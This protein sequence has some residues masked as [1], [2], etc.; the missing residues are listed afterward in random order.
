MCQKTLNSAANSFG[1]TKNGCENMWKNINTRLPRN[2]LVGVVY[3]HPNANIK[4]F[5]DHFNDTLQKINLKDINC[6]ILGNFNINIPHHKNEPAA[7]WINMVNFNRF[8]RF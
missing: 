6:V 8:F 3:R 2:F 7:S 4:E 5:A 1:F